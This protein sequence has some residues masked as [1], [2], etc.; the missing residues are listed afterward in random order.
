MANDKLS[1]DEKSYF[2]NYIGPQL[3]RSKNV[4]V[5]INGKP[6]KMNYCMVWN[7]RNEYPDDVILLVTGFGSGWPGIALLASELVKLGHHVVMVSL[8]G[9]GNSDNPPDDD[10]FD[11]LSEA[12][13]LF[14]FTD[15]VLRG[16]KFI[17]LAIP[18]VLQ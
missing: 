1:E 13:T 10:R 18:W 5:S 14:V 2:E 3:Q 4:D 16:K 12:A 7:E 8:L 17:W 11:F 6:Y 15:L 9:Y